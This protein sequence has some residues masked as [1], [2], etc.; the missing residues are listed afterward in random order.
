[1]TGGDCFQAALRT[2]MDMP[3]EEQDGCYVVHGYPMGQGDIEGI[4]FVHAWVEA[5]EK[6]AETDDGE[7]IS[8]DV[9]IDNSNGKE[10]SM[11]RAMY[12]RLGKI[13]PDEVVR[14]EVQEAFLK[15][16]TTG[17][18]GPWDIDRTEEEME[19]I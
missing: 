11:P 4:R 17:H 2:V 13:D 9:V 1:M 15:A 7:S 8:I 5:K 19:L 18:Y 12:Y 14:Y 16:V 6:V 3:K 10:V